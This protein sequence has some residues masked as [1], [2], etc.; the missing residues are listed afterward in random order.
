MRIF[1]C[2]LNYAQ[3]TVIGH[4]CVIDGDDFILSKIINANKDQ[5][6]T[7]RIFDTPEEYQTGYEPLIVPGVGRVNIV[8]YGANNPVELRAKFTNESNTLPHSELKYF[9]Q[10]MDVDKMLLWDPV[11]QWFE[12]DAT[13]ATSF[14]ETLH[15]RF[16][17]LYN[18]IAEST[19]MQNAEIVCKSA[20]RT[21]QRIVDSVPLCTAI[22]SRPVLEVA[23]KEFINHHKLSSTLAE[24]TK[25]KICALL[26]QDNWPGS[27]NNVFSVKT[28]SMP[29]HV[30]V[31]DIDWDVELDDEETYADL[32]LPTE[33]QVNIN[34]VAELFDIP[35]Y[36]DIVQEVS[37]YLSDKYGYCHNGF[38]ITGAKED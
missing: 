18:F 14:I 37:E 23:T 3:N 34:I 38:N 21:L 4:N 11:L 12:F 15:F 5:F 19:E 25:D 26:C 10:T 31:T 22:K 13:E 36:D 24:S 2:C 16:W 33:V 27:L 1:V 17:S 20:S 29:V 9:L 8:K 32:G 7:Y 30:N 35:S 6:T 28:A